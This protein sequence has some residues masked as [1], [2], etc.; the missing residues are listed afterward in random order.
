VARWLSAQTA[1]C[2]WNPDMKQLLLTL[3]LVTFGQL[4]PTAYAADNDASLDKWMDR[5]L[6]P[7]VISQLETHPRFTDAVVRFVVM[8]DGKPSATTST[9]A[10]ALRDRLQDAV[11][12]QSGIRVGWQV[13]RRSFDR[14]N[15]QGR[16]DCTTS[17]VHY[18][19]GLELEE[20][21]SG[22]FTVSVR[23]LDVEQQ[24]WVSGFGEYW[25]GTLSTMQHRA[26]RQP[27]TDNAYL[28]QRTV[29]FDETQ[30]DLLAAKLAHDLGCSLLREMSGEYVAHISSD[31]QD[32]SK[33]TLE[34]ISNNLAEYQALKIMPNGADA[35]S[36][37]QARAH[38]IDDD[39]YQYWVTITPGAANDDM[40]TISASAYV[41][42]QETF[43]AVSPTILPEANSITANAALLRSLKIISS[44]SASTCGSYA[45]DSRQVYGRSESQQFEPCFALEAQ[46]KTDAVVFFLYHQL[47]NGLV[48]LGGR[49]CSGRSDARIARELQPLLYPLA[50]ITT[51]PMSWLP[52]KDWVSEPEADTFYAIA[53]SD[54]KAA[55]ALGHH[56]E[57]LPIRCG[58]SV[59][60][61]LEGAAL[62]RW[63]IEFENITAH[64]DSDIDWRSVRVKSVY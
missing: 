54:T 37:I 30:T 10:L 49:D 44:D 36:V 35:N 27:G 13:D 42:R 58:K 29:P 63:F 20:L 18:Y 11:I 59:R 34:L 8:Q 9:L 61:G 4:F 1:F 64:W 28:G 38:K 60:P 43:L 41:Y 39:L 14:R 25:Q 56:F 23:A 48:R 17:D 19:I 62:Q 12:D 45:R 31:E 57:Q 52:G 40:P 16:V 33:E 46:T 53:S 32:S 7:A 2:E 22:R 51:Q 55:R 21:R 3:G 47:N 50:S 6:I 26:Y 24:S 15:E 5:S